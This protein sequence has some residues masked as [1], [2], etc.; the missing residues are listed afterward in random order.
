[1]AI[2][3]GVRLQCQSREGGEK[4]KQISNGQSSLGQYLDDLCLSFLPHSLL[5]RDL[6]LFDLLLK[7]AHLFEA[8]GGKVEAWR[9]DVV[10][11]FFD[12]LVTV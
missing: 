2:D 10:H 3:G 5:C 11:I 1:M 6:V 7:Q 12:R 4:I 9:D 8:E